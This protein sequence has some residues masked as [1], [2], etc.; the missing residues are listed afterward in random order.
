M[1]SAETVVK[2]AALACEY[3]RRFNC[4]IEVHISQSLFRP[5]VNVSVT[6]NVLGKQGT[7]DDALAAREIEA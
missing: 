2:E 3:A 7:S 6:P 4:T 1:N 5:A